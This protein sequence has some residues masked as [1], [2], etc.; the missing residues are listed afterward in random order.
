MRMKKNEKREWYWYSNSVSPFRKNLFRDKAL[1]V[2][3]HISCN[4]NICY[5]VDK[6]TNVEAAAHLRLALHQWA[7][8][9]R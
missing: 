5:F 1:F 3:H 4:C 9:L 6:E 2:V 8:D 7:S